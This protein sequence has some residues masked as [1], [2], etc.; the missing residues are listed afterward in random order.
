VD[1]AILAGAP[2]YLASSGFGDLAGKIT[3]G[4]D[5]IIAAEAGEWGAP[6]TESIDPLCWRM[7]QRGL[8]DN[9][10]ASLDAVRRD[11]AAIERLFTALAITGFSMQYLK[12]SRPVSGCEHLL[13]HIWEMEN[14]SKDG[15][16]VTHGHKVAFGTLVAASFTEALFADKNPPLPPRGYHRPTAAEREAEIRRSFSADVAEDTVKIALE[17]LPAP[18]G[19]GAFGD[20]LRD[21]WPGL[22]EKVL[23]RLLSFGDLK[24]M[25]QKAQC[26]TRPEDIQLT[27]AH[28]LETIP[29]A[30][31]IRNRY[32]VL[33]LAWDLGVMDR[34]LSALEQRMADW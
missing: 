9:L 23:N 18:R 11:K 17:K 22:R 26:P 15:Q 32:T 10:N 34:T 24:A 1:P 16:P 20:A 28:V 21:K 6:G 14:L 30:Q 19:E 29:R 13:S 27:R 3:A 31:M 8:L 4:T 12:K 7:V 25:L 5:W 33:D 2:P